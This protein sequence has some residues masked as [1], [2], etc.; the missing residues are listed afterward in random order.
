MAEPLRHGADPRD[1]QTASL[2]GH[3]P[4]R[5]MHPQPSQA[6]THKLLRVPQEPVVGTGTKA[7]PLCQSC[8]TSPGQGAGH[9]APCLLEMAL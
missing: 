9:A 8:V 4:N 7:D 5:T 2:P 1:P 3:L 6:Y